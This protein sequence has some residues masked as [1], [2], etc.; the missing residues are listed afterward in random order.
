MPDFAIWNS[1]VSENIYV[2]ALRDTSKTGCGTCRNCT[3]SHENYCLDGFVDTYNSHWPDGRRTH[4]GCADFIRVNGHFAF[5][6]PVRVSETQPQSIS[7]LKLQLAERRTMIWVRAGLRCTRA[8]GRTTPGRSSTDALRQPHRLRG[9]DAERLWAGKEGRHRRYRRSWTLRRAVC[10]CA[11]CA[12]VGDIAFA[13]EEGR[14][15]EGKQDIQR[16][17]CFRPAGAPS[18]RDF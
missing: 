5:K 16:S 17:C 15:F 1:I 9:S 11:R 8:L 6:I 7:V 13:K 2:S 4:G 3:N 12:S 18:S 14:C 10:C